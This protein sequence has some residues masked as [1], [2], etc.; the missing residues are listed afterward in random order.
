MSAEEVGEI[1][2]AGCPSKFCCTKGMV[3]RLRPDEFKDLGGKKNLRV[4]KGT[5]ERGD[6]RLDCELIED[7][8]HLNP[9]TGCALHG[10][11]RKPLVCD[12]GF[13]VGGY[14]CRSLWGKNL[15]ASR[16]E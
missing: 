8:I 2:C 10:T 13:P 11:D 16:K 6:T 3:L 15:E 14:G 4:R 5:E 1:T 9:E 7:C 12:G